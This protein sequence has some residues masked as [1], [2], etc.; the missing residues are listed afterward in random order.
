MAKPFRF[1]L[2]RVLDVRTQL[3]ERAKMELGKAMAACTQK[4][5]QI[6]RQKDAEHSRR[7]KQNHRRVIGRAMIDESRGDEQS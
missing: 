3:E 6:H 1:N 5:Q 2:E 4:E 7:G